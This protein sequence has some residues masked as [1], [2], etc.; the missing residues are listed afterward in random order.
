MRNAR[1]RCI[2]YATFHLLRVHFLA[3]TFSHVHEALRCHGQPISPSR[4]R[5]ELLSSTGADHGSWRSISRAHFCFI[6]VRSKQ[7]IEYWHVIVTP[8]LSTRINYVLTRVGHAKWRRCTIRKSLHTDGRQ[9][10]KEYRTKRYDT[11]QDRAKRTHVHAKF[12]FFF[13]S[14]L[15]PVLLSATPRTRDIFWSTCGLGMAFPDSYS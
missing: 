14:F 7:N 10:R 12:Y 6:E 4:K 5:S 9:D 13:V 15:G 3:Y 2:N 1:K 11:R 8:M